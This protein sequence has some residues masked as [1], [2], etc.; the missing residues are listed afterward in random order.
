M[1]RKRTRSQQKDQHMNHITPD[2]LSESYF[3]S[4]TSTQKHKSNSFFSVPGLFVGFNPK[5]SESDSVRSPTSPL[6]FKI[7]SSFGNPFRY[8]RSQN[9]GCQKSWDCSKVGLG[10]IDSLDDETKQPSKDNQ[11]SNSKN[12][13]IGRQMCIK[14]PNFCN[15]VSSLET[16]KSLPKNIGV[17][18]NTRA[19][20]ANIQKGDS[21]VLFE[22]GEAAIFDPESSESFRACSLDSGGYRSHITDFGNRKS[23]LGSGK[24]VPRSITNQVPSESKF[25][26]GSVTIGNSFGGKTSSIAPGNGFICSIPAS[27]IELS[28]DYTCV[29]VHGPNP[30]VTHIFCDC[31]LE[32]HNDEVTNFSKKSEDEL[33]TNEAASPSNVLDSYSTNDFLKFCYSC[34]KELDGEDIYMYRGEKAFCSCDCRSQEIEID[35][36]TETETNKNNLLEIADKSNSCEEFSKSSSLFILT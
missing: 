36:D 1:L 19:K 23:R 17:F 2:A 10:I 7:F 5:S 15:H 14:G 26:G 35:E 18:P 32:S 30:K 28:E 20:P 34:K 12:I 4:D 3:H 33:A 24:L 11:S 29:R 6:D 8:P 25:L 9:E 22:I 16:P 13:L 31:I 27:E 21:D